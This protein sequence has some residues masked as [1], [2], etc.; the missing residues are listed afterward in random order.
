MK[1]SLLFFLGVNRLRQL[2]LMLRKNVSI[3]VGSYGCPKVF[4]HGGKARLAIGKY[5]SISSDVTIFL[6]SDHRLDWV[7]TYPFSIL[8]EK[9]KAHTGHPTGKGDVIIG[10]DVWIGFGA[11][12]LSGVKVGDGAVIGARAVVTKDVEPYTIVAGNPAKAIR[13]RFAPEVID[14]L[15]EIRWW[16]KP[17]DEIIGKGRLL[18]SP[19]EESVLKGLVEEQVLNE[20]GLDPTSAPEPEE[21]GM[22]LYGE[23]YKEYQAGRAWWRK[24]FRLFYLYH[25]R[26]FL[27]G[28]TIDCGCGVGELLR[29]LPEGSVGLEINPSA[30]QYCQKMGLDVRLYN[31]QEDNYRFQQLRNSQFSSFSLCHVLEHLPDPVETLKQIFQ[32]CRELGISSV[33]VVV[34]G[35]VGFRSDATHLTFITE[36]FI[37][38][39]GLAERSGYKL[40]L[41]RYFPLPFRA[42]G[43]Y[44]RHNE[45]LFVFEATTSF[46]KQLE[47]EDQSP[48]NRPEQY[49]Q[50][51]DELKETKQE[52]AKE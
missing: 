46:V 43:D 22:A 20:Q 13:R 1:L 47:S 52:E 15:L 10:N 35:S 17:A 28:P 11:T 41:T 8:S 24:M 49:G 21:S 38:A 37:S 26:Y 7:S 36:D 34:P 29:I 30:V 16:D 18:M 14:K 39:N 4:A 33:V 27:K 32:S 3:G 50:Q 48:V 12:I 51:I 5:C 45:T 42:S 25:V 40:R 2:Y 44:F 19:P 23:D 6:N 31:P 9:N